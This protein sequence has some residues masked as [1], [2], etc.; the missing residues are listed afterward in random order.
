MS[1]APVDQ[2]ARLAGLVL[3]R[4]SG[5]AS[6]LALG[7][8]VQARVLRPLEGGHYLVRILGNEHTL[9]SA[10]PLRAGETING[11]VVGLDER[12]ELERLQQQAADADAQGGTQSGDEAWFTLGGGR[13]AGA[14]EELFRR[15]RGALDAEAAE[16]LRRAAGRVAR[17]ERMALA[18]L[19]LS[20]AGL[21]MESELLHSLYAALDA[22]SGALEPLPEEGVAPA[23]W[24]PA[25]RVLNAQ[26]GGAVSHRLG[27][28]PLEAGDRLIEID[29]ALFEERREPAPTAP[30]KHRKLVLSLETE[31][32]GRLEL[33]AVM[34]DSHMRVAPL[35]RHGEG[36]SRSLAEAGWQVDEISYETRAR[37]DA[38]GAVAAAA[39]HLI[40][41]G[42]VNRLV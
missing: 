25:Q 42:S 35:L 19:L 8:V 3:Q 38:N 16:R 2:A 34:T 23:W 15:H 9:E 18:G 21:P 37:H 24:G 7:Q 40:T 6:Q 30:M 17:P 32:L 1:I 36:L 33:R 29:A 27:M 39:E 4:D 20:K 26:G 22:R 41:P 11:R 10:T 13:A 12:I 14:I 28:L 5:L 31:R